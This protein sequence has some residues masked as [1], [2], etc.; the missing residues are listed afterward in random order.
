L[1]GNYLDKKFYLASEKAFCYNMGK[2]TLESILN[3][4]QNIESKIYVSE[5]IIVRAKKAPDRI[6]EI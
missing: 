1:K 3:S 4:L 5:H 2:I 6:L